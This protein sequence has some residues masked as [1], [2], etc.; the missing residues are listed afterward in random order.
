MFGWVSRTCLCGAYF[1]VER[2]KNS[3][4]APFVVCCVRVL[5]ALWMG[6]VACGWARCWVVGEQALCV[7]FLVVVLFV[8]SGREHLMND[9]RD[10]LLL[11]V[12]W[13]AARFKCGECV[14]AHG[15][16]LGIRSR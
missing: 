12:I 6:H 10:C 3:H 14:R 4:D 8:N 2:H 13:F 15:G 5:C 11:C 16:C 9:R 7:F 1:W